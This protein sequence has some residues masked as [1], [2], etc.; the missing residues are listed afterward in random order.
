M[1]RELDTTRLDQIRANLPKNADAIAG[2]TAFAI[3]GKAK[4]LAPHD[5]YAL[6][7]GINTKK[8]SNARY[9]VQDSTGIDKYGAGYGLYQELGFHHYISGAFIQNPFMIPA[10]EAERKKFT[11]RI[12]RELIK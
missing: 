6:R 7:Q 8:I 10:V 5:T 9:H 4:Q 12:A 11:Q 3:E 1:R 2:K